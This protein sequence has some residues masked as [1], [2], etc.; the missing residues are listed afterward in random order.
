MMQNTDMNSGA[1]W[2]RGASSHQGT[3]PRANGNR[4]S[5]SFTHGQRTPFD[6][7]TEQRVDRQSL[8]WKRLR[9]QV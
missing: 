7:L 5:D 3:T 8:D 2:Y 9:H 4:L 6:F 1:R